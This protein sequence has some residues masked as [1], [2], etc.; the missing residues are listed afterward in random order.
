MNKELFKVDSTDRLY[1]LFSKLRNVTISTTSDTGEVKR[2]YTTVVPKL[3][4]SKNNSLKDVQVTISSV[5][6][7]DSALLHYL[8]QRTK[9]E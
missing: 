2:L 5:Q 8:L 6:E 4:V 7:E 9:Y 1:E 3:K